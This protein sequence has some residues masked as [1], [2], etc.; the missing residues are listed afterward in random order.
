[1]SQ[2]STSKQR[3]AFAREKKLFAA[4]HLINKFK[5]PLVILSQFPLRGDL[6]LLQKTC[7]IMG[8]HLDAH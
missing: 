6:S 8:K 1:L 2:E 7:I 3:Q 4:V 5:N